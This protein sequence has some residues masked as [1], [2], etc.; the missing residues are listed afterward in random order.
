MNLQAN[1]LSEQLNAERWERLE[2]E[3]KKSRRA[4]QVKRKQK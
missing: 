3:A 1:M 4:K 2:R